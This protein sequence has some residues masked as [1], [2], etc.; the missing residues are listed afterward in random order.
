MQADVGLQRTARNRGPDSPK[1][2]WRT[3]GV[4]SART[5]N[6]RA[7]ARM[8]DVELPLQYGHC[9]VTEELQ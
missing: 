9:T 5:L 8:Y 3:R 7:D 4:D 1:Q 2:L 6:C